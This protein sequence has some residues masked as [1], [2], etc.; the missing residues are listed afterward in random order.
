[1]QSRSTERLLLFTFEPV[2]RYIWQ[3]IDTILKTY[4]GS[5]PLTHFL[6]NYF[7]QHPKLG[8]RD[9]KVLSEMA[10]CWYRC[11]KGLSNKLTLEEKIHACL[12]ICGSTGKHIQ[13]F[14]PTEEQHISIK[15]EALFP[16]DIELSA[17]IDKTSWLQSML[18][19]P[20]MFIRIRNNK[21]GIINTLT[22][23]AIPYEIIVD[24]CLSLPNGSAVDKLLNPADY[25]V[26]DASSQQTGSFFT[27]KKHQK[28]WDCCCGAGGKSLLLKDKESNINLTVSDTRSSILHNL[29][30]RFKLYNHKAPSA[31]VLDTADM[32]ATQNTVG[33]A[34]FDGI[35]CDVPCTGSGTWARTPEQLYFFNPSQAK[36][37]AALQKKIAVNVSNYLKPDGTMY[38]ITCSVFKEE[39]EEVLNHLLDINKD[40]TCISSQ[41]I[42][43]INT[44]ADSMYIAVLKKKT[45]VE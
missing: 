6:K 44:H 4:D 2:L 45:T 38:Y 26:Q 28:W 35:I 9:R 17:G 41:L 15:L 8:S 36:E 21:H 5:L 1:V 29:Q 24:N 14:L 40:I 34:L 30:E 3:H 27:P 31:H 23:N 33:N 10:Y 11:E 13:P 39:N 22:D 43:G 25:A 18:A 20:R 16:Y 42:N 12:V 7:R 32:L 37:I 19:Q